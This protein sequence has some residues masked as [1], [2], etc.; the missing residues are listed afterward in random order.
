MP[1][2]N[3]LSELPVFQQSINLELH[4]RLAAL[5]VEFAYPTRKVLLVTEG[6][7]SPAATAMDAGSATEP[8]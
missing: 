8:G 6:R 5:G 7:S 1:D 4:R 3:D 2:L